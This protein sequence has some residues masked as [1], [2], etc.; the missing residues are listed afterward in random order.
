MNILSLTECED[1]IQA[2]WKMLN[3]FA[4]ILFSK[5]STKFHQNRLSFVKDITENIL[6]SFSGRNVELQQ[7]KKRLIQKRSSYN[8][9]CFFVCILCT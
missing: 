7:L 5:L 9:R 6:V 4:E 2:R 3:D 8:I 1:I